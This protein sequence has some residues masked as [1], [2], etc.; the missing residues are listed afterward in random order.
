MRRS[1]SDH[2]L[3]VLQNEPVTDVVFFNL[4]MG[5]NVHAQGGWGG[6]G[7]PVNILIRRTA[8]CVHV[9][10][11][12]DTKRSVF[13]HRTFRRLPRGSNPVPLAPE[14]SVLTKQLPCFTI[15]LINTSD[16]DN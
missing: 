8:H 13:G 3:S 11:A 6:G 16:F 4:H 5:L 1:I 9:I 12:N 15:L 14:A 10:P 7:A 2:Y